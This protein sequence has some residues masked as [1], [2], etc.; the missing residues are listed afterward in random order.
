MANY[1][2]VN[3]KAK[4]YLERVSE[5]FDNLADRCCEVVNVKKLGV[6]RVGEEGDF[7]LIVEFLTECGSKYLKGLKVNENY[8]ESAVNEVIDEI[9]EFFKAKVTEE[10][11]DKFGITSFGVSSDTWGKD[12][13]ATVSLGV[14][15]SRD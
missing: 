2:V 6:E 7:G 11:A 14:D 5:Y 10:V 12:N 3:F 8:D 9:T 15:F 4:S 1:N 13:F